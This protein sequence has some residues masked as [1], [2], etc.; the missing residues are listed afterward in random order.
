VDIDFKLL[1]EHAPDVMW[2]VDDQWRIVYVNPAVRELLGYEPEEVIGRP[3]VDLVAASDVARLMD[4]WRYV[5]DGALV[6]ASGTTFQHRDGRA[7]YAK[8]DAVPVLDAQ[9]RFTGA[10]GVVR[11][12]A[13]AGDE[14]PKVDPF[15][16]PAREVEERFL[17]LIETLPCV[18][19]VVRPGWPPQLLFV[20]ENI[21]RYI[22]YRAKEVCADPS[23]IAHLVHPDD[24]KRVGETI[25]E[26]TF[27]PEPYSIDFRVCHR[28]G[29]EV[30]HVTMHSTP[31]LDPNGQVVLRH[32]ILTDMTAQ[33]RLEEELRQSQRLAAIGE[34]AAMMAHEIR[35]PL[36]GMALAI[37]ALRRAVPA[38]AQTDEC[39]GDL[40]ACLRRIDATVGRA[41][42]FARSYPPAFQ[43]C[44]FADVV[45]E[46]RHL[47]NTYVRK[48]DVAMV[49]DISPDLPRITADPRQL[50]Q[51][52]VNLILNA[53]KAM[54]QGGQ[55]TI[56]AAADSRQIA[57][58]VTD[59]GVGIDPEQLESIFDPFRSD[60]AEGTG[61]GLPL[62][63]RILAAH[64]GSIDI[65][66][67]PG[68]GS[69]VHFELPLEPAH[70]AHTPH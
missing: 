50:E 64:G 52:L 51:V 38:D 9:E 25:G 31:I 11:Q 63:R 28:N 34:M 33:R 41:L 36:A 17:K 23:L 70:A 8:V 2:Q 42:G 14:E 22:G 13:E 49:V 53:C 46:A 16:E 29:R 18:V 30:L 54:P 26:A 39:L 65:E 4:E 7:V 45:E 62:C 59:T 55:L 21:K 67:T 68:Q 32:G 60:F 3:A 19:Y 43:P 10:H 69:T 12:V 35:N 44:V 37:R 58:D 5:A 61:L 57:V 66:S 6:T 48:A 20:S 47:T 56:R 15:I 40:D 24:R 1:V 27:S